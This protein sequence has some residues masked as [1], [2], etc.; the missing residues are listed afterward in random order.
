MY[1]NENSILTE[2]K[3]N[4]D[5][6]SSDFS[7]QLRHGERQSGTT[8]NLFPDEHLHDRKPEAD[9]ARRSRFSKCPSGKHFTSLST[10]R[11][12]YIIVMYLYL[13]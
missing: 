3:T 4:F 12:E 11:I 8:R 10:S 9:P 13:N 2:G 1:L 6:F 5:D 7:S